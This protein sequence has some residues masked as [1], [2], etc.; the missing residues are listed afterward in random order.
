[1]KQKKQSINKHKINITDK[2]IKQTKYHTDKNSPDR[3]N[4]FSFK[5]CL[6]KRRIRITNIEYNEVILIWAKTN[7]QQFAIIDPSFHHLYVPLIA[8]MLYD[9]FVHLNLSIT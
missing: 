8:D 1:M 2:S 5:W 4:K 9:K 7:T 3:S 6:E